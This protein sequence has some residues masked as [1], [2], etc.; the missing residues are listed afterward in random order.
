MK[1][2]KTGD[3]VENKI[4]NDLP[5][6]RHTYVCSDEFFDEDTIEQKFQ[7]MMDFIAQTKTIKNIF[8]KDFSVETTDGSIYDLATEQVITPTGVVEHRKGTFAK[9]ALSRNFTKDSVM[10]DE[11][12]NF[13]D[14]TGIG[15]KLIKNQQNSIQN[16]TTNYYTHNPECLLNILDAVSKG[17]QE[18]SELFRIIE[19]LKPSSKIVNTERLIELLNTDTQ[20]MQNYINN[21]YMLQVYLFVDMQ[22]KTEFSL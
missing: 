20:N 5:I 6:K 4:H 21:R 13:V 1:I 22:L 7:N 19:G 9:Y 10:L 14:I 3:F 11:N 16:F 2:Y 12:D 15:V 18:D 17:Y 8:V